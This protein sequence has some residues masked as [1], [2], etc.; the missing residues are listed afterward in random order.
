MAT[1]NNR[2]VHTVASIKQMSSRR[3]LLHSMTHVNVSNDN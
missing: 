3:V 1:K 2:S